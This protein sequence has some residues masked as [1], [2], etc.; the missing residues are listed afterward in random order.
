MAQPEGEPMEYR[1]LGRTGAQVGAVGLGTEYL[2][3]L[4]RDAVARIVHEALDQGINYADLFFGHAAIRDNIGAALRGRRDKVMVAGHLG[5]ALRGE[6]YQ[7]TRDAG[8]SESF[9]HDLL[10]R[11]QTDFIDVLMLHFVD[12]P[13]E[14]DRVFHRGPLDMAKR[15]QREGKAR[16]IGMS[17]HDLSTALRAV[18]SGEIDVLMFP[19]NA[20]N[21]AMPDR[22]RLLE[23]CL[24]RDVGL[25]AMKPYAGGKLLQK[26]GTVSMANVHSGWGG[27]KSHAAYGLSPVQCLGYVLAQRGVST[28]VPGVKSLQELADALRVLEASPREIDLSHIPLGSEE[29][30]QVGCVYCNHCL[31]CPVEIDI[32]QVLRLADTGQWSVSEDLRDGYEAL[33]AKASACTE[34]GACTG[35]CPYGVDVI[36]AMKRAA[37]LF[38]GP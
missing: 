22:R 18:E 10:A 33:S 23:A 21:H 38:E 5:S 15:F 26:E 24:E 14:Y 9:F 4:S 20:A 2:Q 25:V 37:E 27:T 12:L 6:Q 3:G 29:L 30:R 35:R 13:E 19:L 32:G 7:K 36:P 11:L 28:V 16:Y 31:P 34:C 8:L 1:R 17:G